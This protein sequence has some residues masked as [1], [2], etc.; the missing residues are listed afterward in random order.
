MI[1]EV[2]AEEISYILIKNLFY[3]IK[4]KKDHSIPIVVLECAFSYSRIFK[5][6]CA[7]NHFF[8]DIRSFRC[9]I[10]FYPED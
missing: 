9:D 3:I 5:I 1:T 10:Q 8:T 7:L 4:G 2:G 6:V